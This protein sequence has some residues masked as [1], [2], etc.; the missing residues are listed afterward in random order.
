MVDLDL[1]SL[2]FDQPRLV[3]PDGAELFLRD[4][5]TQDVEHLMA[6]LRD[7]AGETGDE[8]VLGMVDILLDAAEDEAQAEALVEQLP[9]TEVGKVLTWLQEAKSVVYTVSQPPD[10]RFKLNGQVYTL[11]PLTVGA[12]REAAESRSREEEDGDLVI[13]A[14]LVVGLS[15]DQLRALPHHQTAAL[16]RAIYD[17]LAAQGNAVG[18]RRRRRARRR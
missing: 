17:D 16:R 4:L 8:Q 1:D 3:F 14:R 7:L 2:A 10:T 11:R 18:G 12:F 9:V 5:S 13:I 6:D 15:L